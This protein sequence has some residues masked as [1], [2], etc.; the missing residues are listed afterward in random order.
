MIIPIKSENPSI[1][2]KIYFQDLKQQNH[3]SDSVAKVELCACFTK[4]LPDSGFSL[5][6]RPYKAYLPYT[7]TRILCG[8][9]NLLHEDLRSPLQEENSKGVKV[10]KKLLQSPSIWDKNYF[11][12]PYS[13]RNT[14][15]KSG[16]S[17]SMNDDMSSI[18]R[19][20]NSCFSVSFSSFDI[21]F[22]RAD[23]LQNIC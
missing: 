17:D 8:A 6:E 11:F 2:N 13:V 1:R 22:P 7:R 21:P 9:P 23:L 16:G 20:F 12:L 15:M 4:A 5:G 14:E 3:F 19:N 10:V 18:L